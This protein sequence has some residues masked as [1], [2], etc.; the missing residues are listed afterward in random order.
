MV[1]FAGRLDFHLVRPFPI[2]SIHF[3]TLPR[4]HGLLLRRCVE[5]CLTQVV[6]DRPHGFSRELWARPSSLPRSST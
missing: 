2:T 1:V 3:A 5:S 6:K 4:K